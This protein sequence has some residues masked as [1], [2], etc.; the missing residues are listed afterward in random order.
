M[1]D[2]TKI[3]RYIMKNGKWI[4]SSFWT[5]A[6]TIE[7]SDPNQ[8]LEYELD[9][10]NSDVSNVAQHI[11]TAN[12]ATMASNAD[13]AKDTDAI[14]GISATKF[15]TSIDF[16][17]DNTSIL[18]KNSNETTISSVQ[19]GQS[20][21]ASSIGNY[22]IING[23]TTMSNWENWK[24]HPFTINFSDY[25][26]GFEF[27][28]IN[29]TMIYTDSW[30]DLNLLIHTDPYTLTY[31]DVIDDSSQEDDRL[32]YVGTVLEKATDHITI[33]TRGKWQNS[34]AARE[35]YWIIIGK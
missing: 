23:H 22:K 15:A 16:D 31:S 14:R 10:I 25:I 28:D 2:F 24:I 1:A 26:A 34:S 5:H 13:S 9:S 33:G 11:D 20:G 32:Q 4:L 21:S 19:I 17:S 29:Y 18:L 30:N 12:Y 27:S 3:K 6:D 35:I 8:T 7:M